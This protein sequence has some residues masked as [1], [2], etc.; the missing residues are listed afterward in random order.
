[1]KN[2]S[3]DDITELQGNV[4]LINFAVLNADDKFFGLLVDQI[5]DSTDIAVKPLSGLL[6]EGHE[7]KAA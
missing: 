3:I 6:M 7:K 4:E 2:A 1:M 5:H